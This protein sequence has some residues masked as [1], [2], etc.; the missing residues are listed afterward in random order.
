MYVFLY[1]YPMYITV[2]SAVQ[3][4]EHVLME[5]LL[6]GYNTNIRPTLDSLSAVNASIDVG[7]TQIV[8]FVS[9]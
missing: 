3:T 6:A 7:L 9:F 5:R 2:E 8:D 4:M 1:I